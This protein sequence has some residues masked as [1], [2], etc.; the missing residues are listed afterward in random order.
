MPK[1]AA[2]LSLDAEGNGFILRRTNPEGRTVGMRLSA[3]DVLT[4]AQS[5]QAL[6]E[7]VI[8]RHDPEGERVRAVYATPVVQVGIAPEAI[9]ERILLT[10]I[11]PSA[12]E[13]TF[14]IPAHIAQH[15]VDRLPHF[16]QQMRS[17]PSTR[18]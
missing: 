1:R 14:A 18:Q 7:Q 4:L 11:G 15:L 13:L 2:G 12:T 17:G 8:S 6:R 5:A 3:Q 9:G 10:L 16:L